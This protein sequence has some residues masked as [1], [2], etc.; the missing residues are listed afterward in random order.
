M[1]V[2][3]A[4]VVRDR[5]DLC[6]LADALPDG[7]VTVISRHVLQRGLCTA[8]VVGSPESFDALVID[9]GAPGEPSCYGSDVDAIWTALRRVPGWF[10]ANVDED[11]ATDLERRV[12]DHY[13]VSTRTL[14]DLYFVLRNAAIVREHPM[15]R[16]LAPEDVGL[17]ERAPP[18]LRGAG[19]ESVLAMLRDGVVASAVDDNR[20]VAIAHTSAVTNG[21]AD[22]GVVTARGWRD[23]GLSTACAS[24]VAR[25]I[26]QSGRMPVW[27][28]GETNG[29]SLRV[30][31][32]LGFE[33]VAR[34]VY[35]IREER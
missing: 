19:F 29:A 32:K 35:L 3:A 2:E 7:P 34:R 12:R 28:C 21:F 8:Y 33:F 16:L 17:I 9:G 22:I 27:S 30:A 13:A 24:L 4:R 5:G 18:E 31:E 10:A 14:G 26:Q 1:P 6:Q 25:E 20:I 11:V 23:Q 15:T